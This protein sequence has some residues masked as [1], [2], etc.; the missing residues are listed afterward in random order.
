MPAKKKAA[1]K[2][3]ATDTEKAV[4]SEGPSVTKQ[5]LNAQKATRDAKEAALITEPPAATPD[6]KG[7]IDQR[8]AA[9]LKDH[10]EMGARPK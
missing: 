6:P 9:L 1:P 2:A 3:A 7:D 8:M 4:A 10:Q 5:E